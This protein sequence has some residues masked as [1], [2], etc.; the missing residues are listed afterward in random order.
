MA[1]SI[2]PLNPLSAGS[3]AASEITPDRDRGSGCGMDMTG[4][5]LATPDVNVGELKYRRDVLRR[6]KR[7]A[8]ECLSE[9]GGRHGLGPDRGEL[10]AVFGK[11]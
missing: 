10:E 6:S 3:T 4:L 11:S 9:S 8:L 7:L 5:V 2:P 1:L